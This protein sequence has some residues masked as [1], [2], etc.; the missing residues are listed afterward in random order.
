MPEPIGEPP[1]PGAFS[2]LDW[3]R[4]VLRGTLLT[5]VT[6]GCLALL[7]L[8]R[9]IERPIF[10]LRRP[11]TPYI[12][13]FVCRSAFVILGMGFAT[14]GRPMTM[15][16]AV[17]ANHTSWLDIFTLN[18]RKRIYYVSKAEVAEWPAIG[19]LARATGTVFIHR[20]PRQA[21]SQKEMFVSRLMAGHK[22]MFFPEGTSTDGRRVLP[23]KP[24]LFQAFFEDRLR[25][26]TH[27]QPVSVVYRAPEGQP[28]TFYGWWGDTDFLSSLL[29]VLAA[30]K[31]GR[32]DVYYHDPLRVADFDN[33]KTL[34]VA[35]ETAVR[36]GLESYLLADQPI[37]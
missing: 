5:L 10:G 20:D 1:A 21:A 27:I 18:A 29:K 19:W 36:S 34:S 28:A 2:G 6:F 16:G 22:L 15:K 9:L 14:H 8:V 24:T 25:D 33:R 11:V 30:R 35:A 17:V 7:L 12:T 31:Q 13:Q 23:F 26:Q 32:V 3:V 37:A 4:V